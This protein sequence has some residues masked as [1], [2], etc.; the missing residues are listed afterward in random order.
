MPHDSLL[1][2]YF[3]NH[4]APHFHRHWAVGLSCLALSAPLPWLLAHGQ[5]ALAAFNVTVTLCSLVADYFAIGTVWDDVDRAVA[6]AYIATLIY[7]SALHN[8]PL[9]TAADLVL[10]VFVPFFYS[11]SSRSK[12]QWRFRHALWHYIGGL[13]QFIILHGVLHPAPLLLAL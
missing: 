13:N 11:R 10:L 4:S 7:F 6:A 8:G 9:F 5:L 1:S 12:E 3:G 2:A